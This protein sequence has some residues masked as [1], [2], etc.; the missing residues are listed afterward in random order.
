MATQVTSS[1]EAAVPLIC[2][3]C[4]STPDR[5]EPD[6]A[7]HQ[8]RMGTSLNHVS[9]LLPT[10]KARGR[11]VVCCEF[12][13][14]G[15]CKAV[16]PVV[17]SPTV[18]G[19]NKKGGKK[20]RQPLRLGRKAKRYC[21][22]YGV[23][24]CKHCHDNFHIEQVPLPACSPYLHLVPHSKRSVVTPAERAKENTTPTT[25][26]IHPH[27][28][29]PPPSPSARPKN[30]TTVAAARGAEEANVTSPG[31]LQQ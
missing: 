21:L 28:R 17:V 22:T 8:K 7:L 26:A 16:A 9:V 27:S 20:K 12:C 3:P 30:S 11:C 5:K 1:I 19:G 23:I 10:D 29:V 14:K 25:Q 13:E 4:D 15:C 31:R 6:N 18:D 24:L 2:G